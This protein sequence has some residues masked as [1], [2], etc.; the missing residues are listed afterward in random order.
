MLGPARCSQK[1][2]GLVSCWYPDEIDGTATATETGFV[3]RH[4]YIIKRP[5]PKGTFRFAIPLEHILGFA[6]DYTKVVTDMPHTLN[7]SSKG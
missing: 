5:N 3:K 7:I 4:D 1:A 6:D 2:P